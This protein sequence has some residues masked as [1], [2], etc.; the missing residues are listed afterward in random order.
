LEL[1]ANGDDAE[2]DESNRGLRREG[3]V[4]SDANG[5]M[6]RAQAM[7]IEEKYEAWNNCC[8]SCRA[9]LGSSDYSVRVKASGD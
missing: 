5:C 1:V 8:L 3:E 7:E 6:E 2:D 9:G 4:D